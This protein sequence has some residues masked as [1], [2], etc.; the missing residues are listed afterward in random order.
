MSQ[1][2][3]IILK[4]GILSPETLAEIRRWGMPVGDPNALGEFE[5]APTPTSLARTIA[6]ALAGADF[7]LF[8]IPGIAPDGELDLLSIDIDG[9]DYY[10]FESLARLKPELVVIEFNPTIPNDVMFVQERNI[11]VNQGCSLLALIALVI[12][13]RTQR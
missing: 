12:A 9:N 10:I 4:A 13:I 2:T 1:I 5:A 7:A 11:T 8:P 6:E 3:E